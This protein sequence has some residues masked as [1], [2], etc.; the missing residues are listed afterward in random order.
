MVISDQH[1]EYHDTGLSGPLT[2]TYTRQGPK[3]HIATGTPD[4][5]IETITKLTE[6]T[7]VLHIAR[8]ILPS[9]TSVV[10]D[11]VVLNYTYT[12]Q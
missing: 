9:L 5:R 6:Q 12:R 2:H 3:L 1:I 10:R 7:L 4:Q 8:I 11:S